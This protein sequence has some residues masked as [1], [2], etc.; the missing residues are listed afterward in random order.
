M[1]D[2]KVGEIAKAFVVLETDA[3]G[4]ISETDIAEYCKDK[5]AHYKIPKLSN[6]WERYK[7]LV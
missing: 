2:I 5:L 3:R 4:K 7:R 1:K 6:S